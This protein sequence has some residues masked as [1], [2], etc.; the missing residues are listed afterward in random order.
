MF[1]DARKIGIASPLG[2]IKWRHN[3]NFIYL[4]EQN[5]SVDSGDVVMA[6]E[7]RIR[8]ADSNY[9]EMMDL[10][11]HGIIKLC[12]IKLNRGMGFFFWN[13]VVL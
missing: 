6:W 2:D 13:L 3:E 7:L 12:L 8:L 9:D 4:N 10:Q 1:T 5:W 11:R